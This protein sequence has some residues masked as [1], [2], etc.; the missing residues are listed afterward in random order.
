MVLGKPSLLSSTFKSDKF[1][2]L[3]AKYANDGVYRAK[4][5]ISE[6]SSLA[7]SEREDNPWWRVDLL[8]I[9]CIWAVNILNRGDGK[10]V[11]DMVFYYDSLDTGPFYI[12]LYIS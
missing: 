10:Y 11:A 8:R 6:L 4:G 2:L 12:L 9:H 1:G 5:D 7:H 3:E